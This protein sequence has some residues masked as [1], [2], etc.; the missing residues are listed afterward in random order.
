MHKIPKLGKN[1]GTEM[2]QM[3]NIKTIGNNREDLPD[4]RELEIDSSLPP[5]IRTAVFMSKVNETNRFRVGDTVVEMGWANTGATLQSTLHSVL[6]AR[7]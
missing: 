3:E 7:C 2:K 1:V 6:K 5:A 4:I